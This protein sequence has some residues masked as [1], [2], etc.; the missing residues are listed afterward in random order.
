MTSVLQRFVNVRREE[1]A[2]LLVSA[3]YFFCVLTALMILR[4]AR[5]ALG[6]KSGMDNIRWLFIGT[7]FVSLA[8]NP[9]FSWLVSRFNR[10][11]FITLAYG[12]FMVSLI[13]F[14]GLLT[15]APQSVGEASGM[16]FYVWFSVFNLFCTMIFWALMADRFTFE[17]S[18]R[19]FGTIAVGGTLGAIAGPW[20]ATKLAPTWGTPA[21]LLVAAGFLGVS[22][23]TAWV[24][25]MMQPER[26]ER[27]EA[28]EQDSRSII[29]G[30]A[31]EGIRAVFRS[32]YLLGISAYMLILSV[33][34]TFIYFTRLQMVAELKKETDAHT[35]ILAEIDLYTQ[36]A[37]LVLQLVAAGH[38]MKRFGVS[39]ALA[40]L[41][42]MMAG[43]FLGLAIF[44]SLGVL[45][46]LD[47]MFK[48]VQRSIMRPARETLFTV[49]SR[50]DKYKSKAFTDTFV[51]RGG[52]VIGAQTE[53]VIKS[54]G[55]GMVGLA[56]VAIPITLVWGVL[57]FWL[58]RK[59]GA[60]QVQQE[61]DAATA[62]LP[63]PDPVTGEAPA[64]V[65]PR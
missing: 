17:Q 44:S 26:D 62:L 46:A 5:D 51:Y 23:V 32:R 4:P 61:L 60:I 43:G 54:L 13:G 47:V 28:A 24:I 33:I 65:A 52:D 9:V 18:K 19:L 27:G 48:S 55:M 40:L 49:V 29:G 30:S 34:A 10:V 11:T 37:T 20:L 35:K 31:W 58:G 57:G 53:A 41:P 7:A 64:I 63:E 59:S 15:R 21:L 36:I 22:I 8:V 3:F 6:M 14:Y 42:L 25:G 16:V 2:P 39:V 12:F 45:V 38:V 1:I 50:A 56:S